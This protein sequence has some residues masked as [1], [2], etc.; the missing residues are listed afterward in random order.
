M[1]RTNLLAL[2]ALGTMAALAAFSQADALQ[3]TKAVKQISVTIII[4]PSPA[5]VVMHRSA[6]VDAP[7][8]HSVAVAPAIMELVADPFGGPLLLASSGSVW[9]VPPSGLMIAQAIT[10]QPTPVP[11]RFNAKPD[12][13]AAYFR[14]IPHTSVL[15]VPYGTTTFACV[16]E[17]FTHYTTAHS[18]ADWAWGTT[19]TAQA[20][21]YPMQNNPTTSYLSWAVPDLAAT[22][23]AYANA[24]SPGEKTWSGLAGQ[25][26][27]HCVDLTIV[28]PN[29]QPPDPTPPYYNAT[30]QYTL[31][32]S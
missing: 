2:L 20:G 15:N 12:P 23:H 31:I 29:S 26:Q 13:N 21:T 4:T 1:T 16:F 10:A 22:F 30:A 14:I 32:V 6:P 7:P 3:S 8:T 5:P 25:T 17:I 11:V 18:L 9:D 19:N 28:V 27:Q 24:G